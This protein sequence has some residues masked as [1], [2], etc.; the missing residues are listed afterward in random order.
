[1]RAHGSVLSIVIVVV[2]LGS[3]GC[4]SARLRQQ[5]ALELQKADALAAIGCHG[6]LTDALA[7]YERIKPGAPALRTTVDRRIVRTSLLLAMRTKELGL[8]SG[9]HLDRARRLLAQAPAGDAMTARVD[10]VDLLPADPGSPPP[11][12]ADDQRRA[13]TSNRDR[14]IA[15]LTRPRGP[16]DDAELDAYIDLALGC[17]WRHL[18][19]KDFSP[20]AA[21]GSIPRT[22][23]LQYRLD[24]CTPAVTPFESLLAAQPRFAEAHLWA[25]RAA[26]SG[27]RVTSAAERAR[28]VTHYVKA[29]DAFP[30]SPAIVMELANTVAI[31]SYREALPLYE[32]V[33]QLVPGHQEAMYRAG[34]CLSYLRRHQQAVATFTDLMGRGRWRIGD[35]LYWRAW[36]RHQLRELEAA[37]ADVEE[38]KQTLYSTEVYTLAGIIAYDRQQLDVARPN[39]EKGV[40][41]SARNCGAAWYL[42]LV[43]AAQ[44]RWPLAGATF[45][46]ASGCYRRDAD[47]SRRTLAGAQAAT[48]LSEQ[49]KAEQIAAAQA[50]IDESVRQEGLAAYNAAFGFV[51]ANQAADARP[52]LD[53]AL[54]H[55]EVKARAEELLEFVNRR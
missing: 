39:L 46:A 27:M 43:H 16:S 11:E 32:R 35:S 23:L 25:A 6:C 51:R 38:A 1:M 48:T 13:L 29:R 8:P 18:L 31:A 44:E 10:L 30:D 55:D 42:G 36:N 45:V 15:R 34:L 47:D 49:A 52:W 22:P 33:L 24:A 14:L 40:E 17:G 28:A 50:A 20:A 4:T 7:V 54:K 3:A 41:L 19:Q 12:T 21:A 5:A 2:A 53:L 26:V 37:W 9:A